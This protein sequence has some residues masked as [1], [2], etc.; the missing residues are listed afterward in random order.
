MPDTLPA[1]KP[2]SGFI[3]CQRPSVGRPACS[4]TG[5]STRHFRVNCRVGCT[6]WRSRPMRR[7]KAGDG[8]SLLFQ[9][10]VK[11]KPLREHRKLA[12]GAARPLFLRAVPVKLDAVVVGV[13]Q[14]KR[15]ADAVVGGTFERNSC[16]D[17]PTER[18]GQRR[19]RGV[20][21]CEM[22]EARGAGLRRL[23]AT[24]FPGVEADVM[25]IATGRDEGG[26]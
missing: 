23:A 21:D 14:I 4:V 24:A 25:V 19:A 3:L 1:G 10:I 12:V 18:V 17:E 2:T 16:G 9:Q 26:L 7:T 13:A 20:E 5:W 11:I 8:A 6:R 22:V 15:F